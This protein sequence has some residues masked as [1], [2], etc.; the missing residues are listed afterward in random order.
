MTQV[1]SISTSSIRA[2]QAQIKALD[3]E[4][5]RQFENIPNVL[6]SISGIGL[7]YSAGIIAE[8]VSV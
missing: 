6:T 1:M 2:M 7:V 4:I 3:K 8:I 5:A